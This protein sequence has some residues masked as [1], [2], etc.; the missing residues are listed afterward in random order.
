MEILFASTNP[1][2]LQQFQFVA[3][4]LGYP[5]KIV[6]VYEKF[7]EV[8]PY[9]E[10][11]RSTDDIVINGAKEI[12]AKINKPVVVEDSIIE[13]DAFGKGPGVVS[14]KYLKERKLAGMLED[15]KDKLNRKARIVSTVGYYD[16]HKMRLLKNAVDGHIAEKIS[17]KKDEP[18]WIGPSLHPFGGGF[19]PV[20]V[21]HKKKKTIADM[22]ADEGLIH[23]YRE[24]NFK[25]VLKH[26]FG[27]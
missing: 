19:N 1:G 23:G 22:T 14:N 24:P 2:K 15:M 17:F 3:D 6:S 16:G 11:F 13:I 21:H 9:S 7:P 12:F 25:K 8:K 5:A 26:I 10:E 18:I 20:F 27:Y 4:S